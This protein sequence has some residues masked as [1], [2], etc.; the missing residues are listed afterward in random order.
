MK[1]I[2]VNVYLREFD[3]LCQAVLDWVDVALL[4]TVTIFNCDVL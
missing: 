1:T 2:F 3:I 4:Y